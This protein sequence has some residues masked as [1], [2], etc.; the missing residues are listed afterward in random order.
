MEFGKKFLVFSKFE[1]KEDEHYFN[2]CILGLF[3]EKETAIK[4]VLEEY[5]GSI[6]EDNLYRNCEYIIMVRNG[7]SCKIH[8]RIIVSPIAYDL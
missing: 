7:Y 2:P 5:R 8:Q 1:N 3:N 6:H 4:W